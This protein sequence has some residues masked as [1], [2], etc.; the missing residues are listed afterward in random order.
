[1]IPLHFMQKIVNNLTSNAELNT[2]A[3]KIRNVRMLLGSE[4]PKCKHADQVTQSHL[5]V[6]A[7]GEIESG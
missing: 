5:P 3:R 6:L 2:D 4:S 1:M 7:R